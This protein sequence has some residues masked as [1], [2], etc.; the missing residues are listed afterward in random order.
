MVLPVILVM[1]GKCT[2]TKKV[3]FIEEAG[4]SAALIIDDRT[5]NTEKIVMADDGS[6][7][8]VHIPSFLLKQ[9]TGNLIKTFVGRIGHPVI[10]KIS[11]EVH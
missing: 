7:N 2:F 8:K 5:E 1:R 10:V 3:R 9:Q 4:A 6:G 11:T